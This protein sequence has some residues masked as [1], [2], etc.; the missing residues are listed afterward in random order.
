MTLEEIKKQTG[1]YLA[2]LTDD[3]FINVTDENL[4]TPV[5]IDMYEQF[6][7]YKFIKYCI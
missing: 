3:G 5:I 4:I 6:D 2:Y 7:M 1:E